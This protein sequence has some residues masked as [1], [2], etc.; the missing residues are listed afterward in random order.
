MEPATREASARLAVIEGR[1][2][3]E[4]FGDTAGAAKDMTET[5]TARDFLIVVLMTISRNAERPFK[6][7]DGSPA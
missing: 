4:Q 6:T 3:S 5:V 1:P 7:D 2:V